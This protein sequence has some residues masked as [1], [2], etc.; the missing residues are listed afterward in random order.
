MRASYTDQFE[1]TLDEKRR[2]TIPYEWRDEG[3][4][5]QLFVFPSKDGC[6]KVYP[7]SWLGERQERIANLPL[8][9]AGRK[10]IEAV[11]AMAQKL[12]WDSQGRVRVKDG[13]LSRAGIDRNVHLVGALD[14][15]EIWEPGRRQSLVPPGAT[16]EEMDI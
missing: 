7:A 11:A 15:F 13:L 10:K 4:E 2:L 6:L 9:D 3:Y 12:V 1:H 5:H 16:L 14:H 8:A